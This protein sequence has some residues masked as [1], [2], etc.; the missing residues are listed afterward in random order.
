M[1]KKDPRDLKMYHVVLKH[2]PRANSRFSAYMKAETPLAAVHGAQERAASALGMD[3]LSPSQ[4]K[5]IFPLHSCELYQM[6]GD[7]LKAKKCP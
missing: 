6:L 1:T 3:N 7:S 4:L 5:K 2:G